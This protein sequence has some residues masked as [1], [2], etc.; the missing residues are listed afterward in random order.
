MEF[1]LRTSASSFDPT[2]S[3]LRE[4]ELGILESRHHAALLKIVSGLDEYEDIMIDLASRQDVPQK[5]RSHARN[6]LATIAESKNRWNVGAK[7]NFA[8]IRSFVDEEK[9]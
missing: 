3:N 8:L 6:M 9:P 2:S 5:V 7:D 4:M 1:L